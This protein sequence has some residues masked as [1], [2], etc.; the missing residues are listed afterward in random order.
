MKQYQGLIKHFLLLTAPFFTSCILA[1]PSQAATFALSQGN[2]NFTDFSQEPSNVSTEAIA[3]TE[4]FVAKKGNGTA[5]AEANAVASFV[6]SPPAASNSSLSTA[7]GE[8]RNYLALADSQATV[9]GNFDVNANTPFSFNFTGDFKLQASIENTRSESAK[10][11]GDI[12]F[13]LVDTAS[14]SVLDFFSLKGDV[15]TPGDEDFVAI[16]KS[17]NVVLGTL[18]KDF[19]FSGNQEFAQ[20]SFQGSFNR[21]FTDAKTISLIEVKQN[22]V[23]VKAVP[24]SSTNLTALVGVGVVGV[25][26]GRRKVQPQYS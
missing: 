10:A 17:D 26:L 3:N 12:S 8:N 23:E 21:F 15:V 2:F 5:Q 22:R 13:L 6:I 11:G 4:V 1:T 19:S 14:N 18:A 24:E 9:V 7:M 25:A 20:A 16:E